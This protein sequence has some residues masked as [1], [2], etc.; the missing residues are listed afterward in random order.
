MSNNQ[1]D[2][3]LS[4]PHLE[5]FSFSHKTNVYDNIESFEEKIAS[6]FSSFALAVNSAT[7]GIHLAL[8]VLDVQEDDFV[9]CPTFTFVATINPILYERAIPVLVDSE[10]TTWNICPILLEKSI[11]DC[12]A[13]GKK[14]KAIIIVHLYGMPAKMKELME[15]AKKYKI[16]V[17]EDMAEALGASYH[18]QLVGTFGDISIVS[19]NVNK[20][21]TTLG[22]GAFITRNNEYLVKANYY[23][24]QAKEIN[25]SLY[26]HDDIGY[27]YKINP[28][29]AH[30]GINQWNFLEER[31]KQRRA[32]FEYYS[33]VI[34]EDIGCFLDEPKGH[35]SNR[36][37]S[38]LKLSANI[39]QQ[40]I[41]QICH[42]MEKQKIQVRPFWNP[43]HAQKPFKK[44]DYYD[45][46]ISN[47]LINKGICLP[48]SSFLS[49]SDLYRVVETL[50]NILSKN[51][52]TFL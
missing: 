37:L 36:W 13:K 31:V 44:Y 12:L 35:F 47:Y 4:A 27:N 30:L 28:I 49:K 16:P 17:I 5:E 48:S 22:G 29:A 11:L 26:V 34:S 25:S 1:F 18:Q 43:M 46:E 14:P 33:S 23:A 20:M 50:S 21:I 45:N 41:I 19:F 32:I 39:S 42:E 2:I 3:A 6:Y 9:I 8:K 24:S 38:C 51:R 15:V 40:E 10:S 52:E 7:A